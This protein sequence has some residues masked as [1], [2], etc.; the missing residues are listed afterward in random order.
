M[1]F[2]TTK[3]KNIKLSFTYL[4]N[5]LSGLS[6][7]PFCKHNIYSGA[8]RRLQCKLTT[9][10]SIEGLAKPISLLD[11]GVFKFHYKFLVG[12]I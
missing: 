9:N 1:H 11:V 5:N 10:E 2:K 12:K 7:F 8:K 4:L 6:N 3:R